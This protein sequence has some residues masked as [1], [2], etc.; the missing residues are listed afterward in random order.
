MTARMR[1]GRLQSRL[2]TALMGPHVLAFMPAMALSSYWVAGE[3]ALVLIAILMPVVFAM[4]G[5]FS[6]PMNGGLGG[7]AS[8][9]HFASREVAVLAMDRNISRWR[10]TGLGTGA[11]A[12]A[13]DD[14]AHHVQDLGAAAAERLLPTV[15]NRIMQ[16]LRD[17]DLVAQL[18]GPRF[19]AALAPTAR[20][21]LE[22]LIQL[23]ARLQTGFEEPFSINQKRVYVSI[24][25]GFSSIHRTKGRNGDALLTAA[26]Q[27]LDDAED[28]GPRTIRAFAP[29]I[30]ARAEVSAELSAELIEALDNGDIRPHFQP[31]VDAKSGALLGVEALA[32]WVHP[33][34]GILLPSRFLPLIATSGHDERLSE[35]VLYQTL[36]ALQKWDE[37]GVWVPNAGVN[38][39]AEVLRNPR[40]AD[41]IQWELDRFELMPE[42][43]TVEVLETVFA[44]SG[45]DLIQRNLAALSKLGCRIDLDDFG[46]GSTSLAH[47]R[48]LDVDRI[49]IDR[50]FVAGIAH[51][52]EQQ[53]MVAAIV[54]LAE[55]LGLTTLAEGVETVEDRTTLVELG[56]TG[57]QGFGI[58]EPMPMDKVADWARRNMVSL[59]SADAPPASTHHANDG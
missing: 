13:I 8:A 5:L 15:G 45:K 2:R 24:S 17:G 55:R 14:Y 52:E 10:A 30:K 47:I 7:S 4:A 37:D 21:D 48:G 29:E 25:I 26:E 11:L 49:K 35:V 54:T 56:V 33:R 19:V 38:F 12:V 31:Q 36:G 58:A 53:G 50:T 32:R 43:I 22:S 1:L 34:H 23:S 59:A 39:S 27:A 41:R 28:Q 42:R 57:V 20:L 46:T 3:G 40:L 6:R 9:L 44:A 18:D 16:E 51:D